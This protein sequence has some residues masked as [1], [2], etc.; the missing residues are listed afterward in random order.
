L[1][2]EQSWHDELLRHGIYFENLFVPGGEL[3]ETVWILYQNWT[4]EKEE[5]R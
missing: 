5:R 1:T 3:S 4:R 2:L